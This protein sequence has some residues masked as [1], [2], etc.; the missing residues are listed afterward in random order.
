MKNLVRSLDKIARAVSSSS[1][2]PPA[3]ETQVVTIEPGLI[4]V[5][6]EWTSTRMNWDEFVSYDYGNQF[7]ER[8]PQES[9]QIRRGLA[10]GEF[11]Y[12]SAWDPRGWPAAVRL[13]CL[14]LIAVL[15]VGTVAWVLLEPRLGG[16]ESSEVDSGDGFERDGVKDMETSAVEQQAGD[17]L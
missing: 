2:E 4:V 1:G 12:R 10:T 17:R 3:S 6:I 14:I 8:F 9:Q 7:A 5:G 15:V 11:R 13:A 16:G